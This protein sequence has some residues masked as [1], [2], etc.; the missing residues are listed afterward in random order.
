MVKGTCRGKQAMQQTPHL[1]IG[2]DNQVCGFFRYQAG[3]Q[4]IEE[5][6]IPHQTHGGGADD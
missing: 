5:G 4:P 2:N 1:A 6:V 3:G